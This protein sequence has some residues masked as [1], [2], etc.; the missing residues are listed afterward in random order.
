[1]PRVVVPRGWPPARVLLLRERMKRSLLLVAMLS[2]P[3]FAGPSQPTTAPASIYRFDV[4]IAGIDPA[5]ATYT[6][7]LAE[8]KP[9]S[10]H[11]GPN[12]PY[13]LGSANT[14]QREQL[15]MEL[16]LRYSQHDSVLLVEGDFDM[17]SVVGSNSAN[18]SWSKVD[19]ADIVVPVTPG[20]STL[21]T[22]VY[23]LA[24]HRRYEVTVTAQRVL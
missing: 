1:M 15:G 18:P 16:K 2:L 8:D 11:S 22:S 10:L 6:L 21:L 9:G 13:A 14:T 23:D 5:P 7:I 17:R 12:I 3:A 20:K 19:V 4:A 24:A